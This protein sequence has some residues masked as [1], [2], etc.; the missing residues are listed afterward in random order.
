MHLVVSQLIIMYESSHSWVWGTAEIPSFSLMSFWWIQAT[1]ANKILIQKYN[2]NSFKSG[3]VPKLMLLIYL[4]LS[5]GGHLYF[6]KPTL[7]WI[8]IQNKQKLEFQIAEYVIGFINFACDNISS[9]I[10]HC[11]SLKEMIWLHW[12]VHMIVLFQIICSLILSKYYIYS[13]THDLWHFLQ[14]INSWEILCKSNY[15]KWN[16]F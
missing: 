9:L 3:H 12:V 13:S 10:L 6:I 4:F 7:T 16:C 5:S 1:Q 15:C 14:C 8:F 2:L 11:A